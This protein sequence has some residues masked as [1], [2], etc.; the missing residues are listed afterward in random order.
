MADSASTIASRSSESPEVAVPG[1]ATAFYGFAR[2]VVHGFFRIWNRLEVHGSENIPASGGFVLAPGAHR[3]IVDTPVTAAS[4][5][6]MLRYMGAEKYFDI[7]VVGGFLR[8]VGGFP[9]ERH[10]TDREALRLAEAIV[11]DGQPL[12][13]F[14]EATRG[15]GPLVSDLKEGAAF[16]A[17]RTGRP[18][19]PLGIGGAERSLPI[20]GN[21]P[22]PSK[23]V[24]VIGAPVWPPERPAGERLKRS[25]VRQLSAELA[26]RLQEVFDEAQIR[27]G[28]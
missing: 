8:S 27:A 12:V 19:V 22:K 2:S 4:T 3:S 16:L 26:E 1:G 14:P 25:Q 20:G 17:C 10:M 18:I 9:V 11:A 21:F 6:R 5:T 15:T 7:P 13:V 24:L 28:A 23:L